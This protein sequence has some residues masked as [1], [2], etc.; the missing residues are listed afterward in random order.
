MKNADIRNEQIWLVVGS[1]MIL[2][3]VA[4]ATVL[5]YTRDV[6]VPFVLAIFITAAVAPLVDFQITRWRFPNWIAVLT[7]LLLVLAMLTLMSVVLIVAVQTMVR[8]ANEYSEQVVH[9]ADRL[10][11][12]LKVHNIP[13]DHQRITSDLE[14]RLPSVI[15]QTAG[16]VTAIVS[17]GFLVVFFVIFLLVGRNPEHRRTDIYADI[18][19]TIRG[20]IT[21]M[22]GLSAL[23]SIL[24][25]LVLWRSAFGWLGFLRFSSSSYVTF[26]I[27]ARSSPL[28][29]RYRLRCE[30]SF[31]THG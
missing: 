3:T 2:A 18:E 13:V 22:T 25:G 23:T 14:S 16:N 17:H 21:T 8:V 26:R 10:F 24:V 11:E 12:E 1:L 15:T 6:M 19:N 27:L 20:Y 4:L 5:V 30:G 7:T 31:K 28:C 9:L 29:C